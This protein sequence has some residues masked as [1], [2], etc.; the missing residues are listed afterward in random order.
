[1]MFWFYIGV[2]LPVILG[3]VG[4]GVGVIVGD[5]P[6]S[7]LG[8]GLVAGFVGGLAGLLVGFIPLSYSQTHYKERTV[9][10][11]V[12]DKDRTGEGDMRVYTDKG[13]FINADSVW[14]GKHNSADWWAKWKVGETY[15]FDVAGW[16]L[17]VTSDFPN[18]FAWE[19]VK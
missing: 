1:M 15:R 10:A 2:A 6:G 8:F 14:R 5:S 16:R 4:V 13:V 12:L 11:K 18:I 9:E 3:A 7:R 17:G 19:A